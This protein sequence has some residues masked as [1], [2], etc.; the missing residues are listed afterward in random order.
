MHGYGGK[1]LTAAPVPFSGG[2]WRRPWS[3]ATC[4]WRTTQ[5]RKRQ[6]RGQRKQWTGQRRRLR[7]SSSA[8]R[9]A[10]WVGFRPS[11]GLRHWK[12]CLSKH[13]R[14]ASERMLT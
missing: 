10:F 6:G 13:F 8:E 12:E 3:R 2:R 4:G 5:L 1:P 14:C 11:L 9:L 7:V